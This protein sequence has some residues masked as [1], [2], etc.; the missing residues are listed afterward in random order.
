MNKYIKYFKV[1][2]YVF[3]PILIINIVLSCLYYFNILSS[4]SLNIFNIILVMLSMFISGLYLGKK[5]NKK[6]YLEG[7]KIGLIIIFLF[8]IISYLAFD[9]SINIKTF[10]YYT[11]LLI[12][13]TIGSMLGI[14]RKK[15]D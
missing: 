12:S 15:N 11:L 5:A 1:L 8:F 2:S 3:M 14:N 9:K 4:K 10:I 7:I 13:S 6:G